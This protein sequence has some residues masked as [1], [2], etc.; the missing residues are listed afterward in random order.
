MSAG[1]CSLATFFSYHCMT[2]VLTENA[3]P[4]AAWAGMC[5][6]MACALSLM[7]CDLALTG[8]QYLAQGAL[9]FLSP[10]L[11]FIVT[12]E[13]SRSSGN[14]GRMKAFVIVSLL[15]HGYSLI[16]YLMLFR[17]RETQTG[18]VL[19]TAFRKILYIDPFG[20]ARHHL[21]WWRRFRDKQPPNLNASSD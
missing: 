18:A 19:P 4:I 7:R 5:V 3:A 8:W 15:L 12:L 2:Y 1:T 6:F 10:M 16:N 14:V 17:V 11:S 13:S 21:V 9:L 20:W